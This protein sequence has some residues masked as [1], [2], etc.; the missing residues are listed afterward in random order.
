MSYAAI[1]GVVGNIILSEMNKPDGEDENNNV[2]QNYSA[3]SDLSRRGSEQY[4]NNMLSQTGQYSRE[5]A[6]GDA[7]GVVANIFRQYKNTDLPQ[8]FQAQNTSGGYN[9]TTTQLLANDAFASANAK[10][11]DAV[12]KNIID[13]RRLQQGDYTT[14]AQLMTSAFKP[15]TPNANSAAQTNKQNDMLSGLLGSLGGAM[16][17]G[18]GG[19]TTGNGDQ[20][21][22]F[23]QG[24]GLF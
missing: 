6:I 5:N 13:Y 11:A 12:L 18:G 10:A 23:M 14:F 22:G 9:G 20:L 3:L 4:F 24:L 19:A 17:S 16:F 7:N 21:G 15:F 2:A 1:I 8:I